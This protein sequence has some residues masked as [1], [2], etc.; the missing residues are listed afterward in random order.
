VRRIV[1]GLAAALLATSAASCGTATVD[2]P[3]DQVVYLTSF[4]N[5][6]RDAY[7]WVAHHKG[8]FTDRG[9][10]V[11]IQPGTGTDGVA[12]VAS[13]RADF[14]AVDFSGGLMQISRNRLDVQAVAL[15]QQRTLAAIMV[16]EADGI[17]TPKDLAGATVAD[18]PASVV[19]MLFPTYARLAGV[20]PDSVRWVDATPQTLIPLLSRPATDA[21]AQ[22]VVG[23]PTVETVIGQPVRLLPY[24][25]YLT[26][27]P[28][29]ALWTRADTDPDLVVRFRDAL[30]DG[31]RYAIA[32]PDEAG[33]ILARFVE[34][35]DPAAAAAEL[36]LMAP[37]VGPEPIGVIDPARTARAIAI[38]QAAGAIEPGYTPEQIIHPEAHR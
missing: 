9:I 23:Q 32:H 36:R 1:S 7:V 20:D 25:D 3:P 30:L 4:G 34:T 38:L 11:Q 27:L 22:Y 19:R 13:G 6:G 26:D 16:R 5:F 35:A 18:F 33:Q 31:L 21:I 29:N 37:Y 15:I 14:A 24:S 28:G 12:L 2:D 17:R 10:K 8:F